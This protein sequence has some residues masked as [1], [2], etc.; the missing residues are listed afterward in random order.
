MNVSCLP[1]SFFGDLSRG[2]MSL[3][4]WAQI[5]ADAGLDGIDLSVMLL[6]NHT[7]VY[8]KQIRQKLES[9]GMP[10]IMMATYP[11]CSHPDPLQRQRELE[12]LR[13]DIALSSYLG[14]KYLRIV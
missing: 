5:A 10:V 1:V 7:P 14:A 3:K 13:H 11:D 12:F 6:K 2:A 8:L 9:T 4:Q